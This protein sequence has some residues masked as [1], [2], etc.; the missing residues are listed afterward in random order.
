MRGVLPIELYIQAQP[1]SLISRKYCISFRFVQKMAEAST[2]RIDTSADIY[3]C[4]LLPKSQV[5]DAVCPDLE[6]LREELQDGKFVIQPIQFSLQYTF[7]VPFLLLQ[8]LH[9]QNPAIHDRRALAVAFDM[10]SSY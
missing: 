9:L 3:L 8:S 2:S 4:C 1:F 6:F 7:I 10:I 5:A